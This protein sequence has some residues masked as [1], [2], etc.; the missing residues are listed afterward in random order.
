MKAYGIV[1]VIVGLLLYSSAAWADGQTINEGHLD[2]GHAT[3]QVQ[4]TPVKQQESTHISENGDS[5]GTN[6]S[7]HDEEGTTGGGH[8][9][10]DGNEEIVETPPNAA[11]LSSFGGIMLGFILYGAWNKWLRKKECVHA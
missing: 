2:G 9:S 4:K 3:T 10:H 6:G 7:T 5:R 11:V 1:V 8:G